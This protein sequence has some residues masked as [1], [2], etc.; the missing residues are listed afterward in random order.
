MYTSLLSIYNWQRTWL[1]PVLTTV[2]GI[3]M[4]MDE[5]VSQSY[6]TESFEH[7]TRRDIAGSYS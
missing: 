5:Q 3:A 7:M 4:N 6:D 2:T 1:F